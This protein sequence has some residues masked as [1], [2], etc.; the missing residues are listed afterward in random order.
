MA[1]D[2][3]SYPTGWAL[4]S[5]F[6]DIDGNV[7]FKGQA[8]PELKGTLPTSVVM[9][10]K[11]QI[12]PP[13]P[14]AFA[15]EKKQDT[16][17]PPGG[18]AA[19]TEK[20]VANEELIRQNEMLLER[21]SRLEETIMS[22]NMAQNKFSNVTVKEEKPVFGEK[23]GGRDIDRG[24]FVDSGKMYHM[25]GRGYSMSS[26]LTTQGAILTAP[27]NAPIYFKKS[28][29]D[30]RSDGSVNKVIPFC[31]YKTNSK[32]E[33]EFIEGH[34]LFG[35]LIFEDASRAKR[36]TESDNVV[37]LEQIVNKFQAMP[38]SVL[39]AT[40]KQSGIDINLDISEIRNKLVWLEV[41]KE[42]DAEKGQQAL[43]KSEADRETAMFRESNKS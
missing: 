25:F 17:L 40:A 6:V 14:D 33:M 12:Y 7:Y 2:K 11:L 34:P 4:K 18:M 36:S 41:T 1:E 24:D 32:K 30:V 28:F 8:Q 20:A 22:G 9:R 26:Y 16:G 35:V 38:Q 13:L 27:Y 15:D 29:D 37:K 42:V 21:L 31:S 3:K 10:G 39:F 23:F 5:E 19:N 43:R